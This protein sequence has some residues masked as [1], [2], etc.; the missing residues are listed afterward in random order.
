MNLLKT[1]IEDVAF[2]L[3]NGRKE[4]EELEKFAGEFFNMYPGFEEY[5]EKGELEK[6][7]IERL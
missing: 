2:A 4:S 5:W 1:S 7:L 3:W 6:A